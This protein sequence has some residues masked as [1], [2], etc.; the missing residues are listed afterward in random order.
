MTTLLLMRFEAN[1]TKRVC[2]VCARC[3]V[4]EIDVA[5]QVLEAEGL[6]GH[7]LFEQAMEATR[8]QR[9]LSATNSTRA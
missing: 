8:T 4:L 6:L 7:R 3:R 5:D 2:L 9:E 1:H